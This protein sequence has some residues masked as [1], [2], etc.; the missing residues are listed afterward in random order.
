MNAQPK[1]ASA[2]P[3]EYGFVLC[4]HCNEIMYT[5][6]TN[7]VKTFYGVCESLNCREQAAGRPEG[8]E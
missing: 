1:A 8:S 2:A 3:L 7:G 6:P 5:L 4:K